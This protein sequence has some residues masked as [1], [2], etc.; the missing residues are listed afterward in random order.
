MLNVLEIYF[1]SLLSG[2]FCLLLSQMFVRLWKSQINVQGSVGH[3]HHK[4]RQYVCMLR[5]AACVLHMFVCSFWCICICLCVWDVLSD[6]RGWIANVT[7][8]G[9]ICVPGLCVVREFNQT[10][11]IT[12]SCS[13]FVIRGCLLSG[14]DEIFRP[15]TDE[16]VQC[17]KCFTEDPALC[18]H[19]SETVMFW[20]SKQGNR[21]ILII[22]L[23]VFEQ[24]VPSWNK[25][26]FMSMTNLLNKNMSH[27]Y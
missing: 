18:W 19:L 5:T 23:C 21:Q 27:F 17:S 26:I 10:D 25:T 24:L 12:V 13:L 2:V 7:V 20:F 4:H 22:A 1:L 8:S 11:L 15:F 9:S 14:A 3:K 6:T 16:N